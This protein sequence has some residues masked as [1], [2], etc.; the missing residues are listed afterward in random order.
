MR[1]CPLSFQI[2]ILFTVE[3]RSPLSSLLR[4]LCLS[5]RVPE[6]GSHN[7]F[8]AFITG[9]VWLVVVVVFVVFVFVVIAD[10]IR[11]I[12]FRQVKN[13]FIILRQKFFKWL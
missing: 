3:T 12:Y 6:H 1:R 9:L 8:L 11:N 7:F 5:R 13:F 10:D 2:Q 4:H